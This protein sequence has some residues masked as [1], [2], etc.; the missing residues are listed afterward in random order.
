MAVDGIYMSNNPLTTSSVIQGK[1][2]S[3]LDMNDFMNLLV[4]QLTN[5]DMLNPASDTEF[6]AQMAQFSS[7]QGIQAIQEYQV[8][9]YAASYTGKYV[10]IAEQNNATGKLETVTGR[11]EAV[12]FYDGSP[13]VQVNGKLY[14]LFKVMEVSD[15]AGGGSMAEASAYIGKRVTVNTKNDQ[16]EARQVSGTVTGVA[17]VNG[18]PHIT[19]SGKDYPVSSIVSVDDTNTS[20]DYINTYVG[21]TVTMKTKTAQG[22]DREITGVV[23]E[24]K[25]VDGVPH[26]VINGTPYE[27]TNDNIISVK[28][29]P[30]S[31]GTG[32]GTGSE[33]GTAKAKS[34]STA[35]SSTDSS[36]NNSA[37]ASS[38]SATNDVYKEYAQLLYDDA[39]AGSSRTPLAEIEA[40]LRKDYDED[41][42]K[43]L[44][45]AFKAR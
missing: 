24:V 2:A 28:E 43:E 17:Y 32:T 40:D 41:K 12:S 38:A 11:V 26:L 8:S 7:L 29:T 18:I 6:I 37:N 33:S 3:Q 45:K 27:L 30:A 20:T 1:D 5:Q 16:N 44:I 15:I 36:T 13:K 10:A 23:E 31:S 9:S 25:Y 14:D 34:A 19:I 4:A 22:E 42:V 35:N 39:K 21:K